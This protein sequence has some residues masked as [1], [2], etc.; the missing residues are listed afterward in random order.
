MNL[1]YDLRLLAGSEVFYEGFATP[2]RS[3]PS[4]SPRP[5]RCSVPSTATAVDADNC[6][7]TFIN[8]ASRFVGA[9]Y[10][11]AQW[12]PLRSISID[13]GV[14]LQKGFGQRPYDLDAALRGGA[15]V[16]LPAAITT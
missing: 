4:P 16:E 8:D 10:V 3:I 6:P 13:G 11:D 12:R 14:R 15:G 5:C 7:R 1:P 2:T 9:V